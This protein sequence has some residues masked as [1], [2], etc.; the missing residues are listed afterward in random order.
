MENFVDDLEKYFNET[1]KEKILEDWAK[2]KEWDNIGITVIEFNKINN[3]TEEVIKAK[4]IEIL[5]TKDFSW[6]G[7]PT[8]S[9][10]QKLLR[11]RYGIN[12]NIDFKPNVKKWDFMPYLM[13]FNGKEYLDYAINYRKTHG[14]RRYDTYEEALEDCITEGLE[15]I[16]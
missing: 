15:M 10:V 16:P 2:T 7:T 14:E 3:M 6:H 9:L 13:F 1:P 8:Q 5:A 4:N 12:C 11:E